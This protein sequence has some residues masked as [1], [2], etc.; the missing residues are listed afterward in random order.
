MR[1][2]PNCARETMRTEDWACQWCGYPLLNGG[3]RL[4]PKT[5]KQL[6]EERLNRPSVSVPDVPDEPMVAPET[7]VHKRV[8]RPQPEPQPEPAAEIIEE[9]AA[10]V[11]E[12]EKLSDEPVAEPEPVAETPEQTDNVEDLKGAVE[13]L[14][15]AV[16]PQPEA[17]GEEAKPALESEPPAE[18]TPEPEPE[19]E[20]AEVE[21][22]KVSEAEL[23]EVPATEP[24]A[25]PVT[26]DKTAISI[27]EMSEAFQ[28]D[29]L[30]ADA[31]FK[32]S[33]ITVTGKV[34][35]VVVNGAN[36]IYYLI[37]TDAGKK[38]IWNVRC[39]FDKQ[40]ANALAKV[41]K[42]QIVAVKG[43]Y[44]GYERNIIMSDCVLA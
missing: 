33:V 2:C 26:A 15:A 6:E 34:S 24:P 10:E 16:M 1:R 3:Y 36:E 31:K 22:E 28:S 32:D 12:E 40:Q 25:Q 41:Q 7:A 37:L 44:K 43:S 13:D 18:A 14:K 39:T 29:K 38:E 17:N 23:A 19:A 11:V 5:Y 8:A 20:P 4:I 42:E 30:A 9:A 27:E 35:R 21:A